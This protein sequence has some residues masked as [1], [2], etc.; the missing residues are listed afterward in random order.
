MNKKIFWIFV[1]AIILFGFVTRI[2]AIHGNNIFFTADQGRDA[3]YVREIINSHAL[4]LRGPE[5]SVRGLFTGPLWYY[6]IAIG[7][8]VMNGNPAG[9]VLMLTL[10]NLSITLV[11]MIIIKRQVNEK[12][13]L[14]IGFGL[15]IFWPFFQTSLY[16]FNPFPLVALSIILILLL[17]KNKYKLALIPVLLAFNTE[18]AGAIVFLIFYILVGFYQVL[19]KKLTRLNFFV[20]ALGIPVI[21]IV[22]IVFDFIKMPKM[23]I[24][25]GLNVFGGTNFIQIF[26]EFVKMGVGVFV[27]IFLI[28]LFKKGKNNFVN[29]FVIL[30]FVLIFISFLFFGSNHGWR[31]WQT[32]YIPPLIFINIIFIIWEFKKW[33]YFLI[34]IILISQILNFRNNYIAYL[35][36][37][38][39]RSLLYNQEKVLDWIYTHNEG[40]GFDLYTYTDSFYDYS[41]QYLISW[42]GETKYG[43]YPCEY[44]NF[45]LSH[46]YLYIQ[47]N[48][49]YTSPQLGC[50]KFRF[51]IIDSK[52]NGNENRN[53]INEFRNETV[54]LEKTQI[55]NTTI[56]KRKVPDIH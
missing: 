10:L 23:T 17:T 20:F 56:E 44:S 36:P 8:A 50:D 22:K 19:Y 11:L 24:N 37:S 39:D 41:Y 31:E 27:I 38:N 28:Y 13:A 42:Y 40:N 6:F 15:Q 3:L 53:W 29:R 55:G 25:T 4:F 2:Y 16:G 33:R 45:P 30:S 12:L 7:Y 32:N 43:F 49:N 52:T 47:G 26:Q 34:L 35:K 1:F 18:L 5:T 51:L 14:L 48:T 46:K 9:S 54:F 21:G